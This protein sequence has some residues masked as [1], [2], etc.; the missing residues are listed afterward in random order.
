MKSDKGID[1]VNIVKGFC[2]IGLIAFHDMNSYLWD[3]GCYRQAPDV[4]HSQLLLLSLITIA[5]YLLWFVPPLFFLLSGYL[6]ASHY[7]NALSNLKTFYER[8]IYRILVPFLAW[9][10]VYLA[11]RGRFS[12]KMLMADLVFA[13]E[14][15]HTWFVWAIVICY[16]LFPAIIR[17]E[18]RHLLFT[19][20]SSATHCRWFAFL[21]FLLGTYLLADII[22]PLAITNSDFVNGV[23]NDRILRLTAAIFYFSCGIFIF[24][25]KPK[26]IP[27]P[28]ISIRCT[29]ILLVAAICIA[30]IKA[31]SSP[32][33][34]GPSF[35]LDRA[36]WVAFRVLCI[37]LTST[38]VLQLSS[39]LNMTSGLAQA[40][41]RLGN[42]SYGVY[43]G[44]VAILEASRALFHTLRAPQ[45]LAYVF[46]VFV[47]TMGACYLLT[48]PNGSLV[49]QTLGFSRERHNEQRQ[50]STPPLAA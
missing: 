39:V 29:T 17:F 2:I 40:L 31:L 12:L 32:Y 37:F 24:R 19:S 16:L 18:K 38:L 48:I 43:L 46:A 13:R 21:S 47:T 10:P 11:M 35:S 6:L 44:H 42:S 22:I 28:L 33:S 20:R 26:D 4:L 3:V 9:Y 50:L 49:L 25:I 23:V 45:P 14:A 41:K 34:E 1:F 30:S 8:R 36:I 7:Q 27:T 15:Y 5:N